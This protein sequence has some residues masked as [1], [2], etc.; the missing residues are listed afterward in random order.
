MMEENIL[1]AFAK[2]SIWP[3]K[4][5]I[6]LSV[7]GPPQLETP[8]K[9]SSNVITTLYTS[10][11]MRQFTRTY[12]KNPTKEAFRKLTKANKTNAT[13]TS[14]AEHQAK[15]LKESLQME[16]KKKHQGKK[17]DLSG[18]LSDKAQFFGVAEVIAA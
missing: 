3:Y 13:L 7:I 5:K 6:I 16:K 8:P 4:L 11:Q 14:I 15:G 18:E 1:L 17:L 10:K 2:T 12:T 9:V